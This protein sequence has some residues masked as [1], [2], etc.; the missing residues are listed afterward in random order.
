MQ[1]KLRDIANAQAAEI[2]AAQAELAMLQ[3]RCIP[4]FTA[5]SPSAC[6]AAA[7]SNNV[8]TTMKLSAG[9]GSNKCQVVAS[10]GARPAGAV[11]AEGS[12]LGAAA[13]SGKVGAFV[14]TGRRVGPKAKPA[15]GG[16]SAVG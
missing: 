4:F 14:P 10:A 16:G 11:P 2:A 13:S 8:S 5:D 1:S 12:A 15:C 7:I 9:A 3:G 6:A